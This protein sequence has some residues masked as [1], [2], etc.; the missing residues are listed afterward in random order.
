MAELNR[1][2]TESGSVDGEPIVNP[3][4][5]LEAVNESSDAANVAWLIFIGLMSYL[6]IA[7]AG[8]THRDLLLET[9]VALPI[10]QVSIPQ[11]QFFQF[12]PVILVL[13]HIGLVSQLVLVARK[14]L[15]FDQAVRLLEAGPRRSHPL[16]LELHNF[17]FAQAIAGPHRSFVLSAFLHAMSW[18]TLVVLPVM[19][20]LFI[21]LR[22][23]PFHDTA[24]TW[25]HRGALLV[26]LGM[27]TM[28]GVFLAR[29][30]SSFVRAFQLNTIQRPVSAL[31]TSILLL[32]A[33]FF[34]MFIV[35]IPEEWLDRT[36]RQFLPSQQPVAD[37]QGRYRLG[38]FTVPVISRPEDGTL[39]GIF[40]RNLDASDLDLV[41]ARDRERER[42]PGETSI[43][44]RAR[45]LRFARLDRTDLH[46]A[47][48][49][50]VKL[51]GA[52][53]VNAD[54]RN[55]K[56]YCTVPDP[57]I[58]RGDRKAGSCA[59]ARF[60]TF[61]GARLSE[62][63]MFGMDLRGSSFAKANLDGAELNLTLLAGASFARASLERVNFSDGAGLQGADF[64]SANLAGANLSTA[65][66]EGANLSGAELQGATLRFANLRGANLISSDLDGADL[67]EANLSGAWFAAK[68]DDGYTTAKG[69]GIDLRGATVWATVPPNVATMQLVDAGDLRIRPLEDG[70]ARELRQIADQIMSASARSSYLSNIAPALAVA[71]NR[72]WGASAEGRRWLEISKAAPVADTFQ[73]DLTDALLQLACK[74]KWSSG[75]VA[76]GLTR[77]ALG[78][79]FKGNRMAIYDRLK[80]EDCPASKVVLKPMMQELTS[81]IDALKN[82]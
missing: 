41:A 71:A 36:G 62:A 34:S 26:D 19:L 8:V 63:R 47:D 23:L 17:F 16:R 33:V 67:S 59:S 69:R 10:M 78:L 68:L 65:H 37:A 15:E 74:T 40:H 21:Q 52:S 61:D 77:R 72:E 4:S 53:L 75:S 64:T 30:E 57:V 73:K 58:E 25:S 12:A 66:L 31:C 55:V 20:I 46:Q 70:D 50:A 39:F 81:A 5:L 32:A 45:D 43:S 1:T 7:V 35:T 80:A 76:A 14:T 79:S 54:L 60:A 9:P 24:V 22:Y 13:L 6:M 56:L 18:L 49:T 82:N 38:G 11:A 2:M 48:M 3:Y 29:S 51:D 28:I 44:L 27:M 42:S